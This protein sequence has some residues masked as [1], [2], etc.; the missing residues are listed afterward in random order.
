M[1]VFDSAE[2]LREARDY[3]RRHPEEIARA[4]R[5]A[6]GL[7]LGVPMEAVRYLT[8]ELHEQHDLT[9]RAAPPGLRVSFRAEMYRTMLRA[10][11]TVYVE[12]LYV[13]ATEARVGMRIEGLEVEVPGDPGSPVSKLL[14][15]GAIDLSKPGK[16]LASLPERPAALLDAYDDRVT[17]DLL[18]LPGIKGN[19]AVLRG[20]AVLAPVLGVKAVRT[21]DEHLDVH[22]STTL[23]GLPKALAVAR[24][25]LR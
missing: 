12:E 13:G 3:L 4:L 11:A 1:P 22:L 20:L 21:R 5:G 2:L 8:R 24:S 15:S 17:I 9:L 6:L 25:L 18:R 10:T 14:A 7:R 23:R 16:L 19:D